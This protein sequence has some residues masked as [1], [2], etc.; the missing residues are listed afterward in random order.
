MATEFDR[1]DVPRAFA[2]FCT[3]AME[4]Q[5]IDTSSLIALTITHGA[6]FRAIRTTIME[7]AFANRHCSDGHKIL[8]PMNDACYT[9]GC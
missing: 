5:T 1:F 6:D 2:D 7:Y 4:L 9:A 3:R 8:C